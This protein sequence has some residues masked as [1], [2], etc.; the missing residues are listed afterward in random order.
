MR[1]VGSVF[2]TRR[3]PTGD[4]WRAVWLNVGLWEIVLLSMAKYYANVDACRGAALAEAA[5]RYERLGSRPGTGTACW[6]GVMGS[7]PYVAIRYV[8]LA[9]WLLPCVGELGLIG[10]LCMILPCSKLAEGWEVSAGTGP[11]RGR[12]RHAG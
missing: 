3:R 2:L 10:W 4:T 1:G 8:E 9:T 11:A 12:D 5:D 6:L 7:R